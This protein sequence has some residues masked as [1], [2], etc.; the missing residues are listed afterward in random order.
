MKHVLEIDS[1]RKSFGFRTILS[2][3]WLRCETGQVIGLLG[4]NGSGK[5]TLLKIISGLAD[6]ES[7]FIEIDGVKLGGGFMTRPQI[8][9]L[10][11]DNFIPGNF[12][13]RKAIRLS[14]TAKAE[15][16]FVNDEM[17]RGMMNKR[18][19]NISAGERRYLEI[20]VILAS[21]SKFVL[22]DEPYN[23]LSPIIAEKVN[24]MITKNASGKGIIITDHSYENVLKVSTKLILMRDGIT[25]HLADKTDLVELGYLK[26][27]MLDFFE[28]CQ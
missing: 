14:I 25:H 7:S 24:A 18:M 12:T 1:V 20:A 8:S 10:N 3:V 26:A 9:Y 5:S 16:D 28:E 11:Q 13:V 19:R 15:A 4:R 21:P 23:G 22:L 6:A 2:D 27:G 17:I